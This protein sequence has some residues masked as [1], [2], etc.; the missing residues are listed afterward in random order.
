MSSMNKFYSM[1]FLKNLK[2]FPGYYLV[3]LTS[4][5][6]LL[7]KKNYRYFRKHFKN[8]DFLVSLKK[9]KIFTEIQ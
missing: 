5:K 4:A 7:I 3:K 9:P 2:I 1:N 6:I 8:F